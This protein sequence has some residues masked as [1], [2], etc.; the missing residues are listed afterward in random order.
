[1]F[2][3]HI[4]IQYNWKFGVW[5]GINK[6][7]KQNGGCGGFMIYTYMNAIRYL[8]SSNKTCIYVEIFI[9]FKFI[10]ILKTQVLNKTISIIK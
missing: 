1:M 6:R 8:K 9:N 4:S 10:A 3:H 2:V 7:K 5:G